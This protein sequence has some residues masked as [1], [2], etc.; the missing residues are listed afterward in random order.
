M[1][2]FKSYDCFVVGQKTRQR[3]LRYR[4]FFRTHEQ[5][6]HGL[7]HRLLNWIIPFS[8]AS[9]FMVITGC[10]KALAVDQ[11]IN[12]ITTTQVFSSDQVATSAMDGI[13]GS[14]MNGSYVSG[15]GYSN[16][17]TTIWCGASADELLFYSVSTLNNQFE[18][19]QLQSSNNLVNLGLWEQPFTIIYSANAMIEGLAAPNG[20]HDSV[21]NEL[22]GEAEVVRAFVNFYLV[23]LFGNIPLVTTTN[24]LKTELLPQTPSTEVYQQIIAD[25]KDAQRRLPGDY[26]VGLGQRII[27]NRYAAAALL[28]TVYLYINDWPDA[29]S[30]AD[31]VIAHSS[32]Y[33]LAPL[34][35]VF[36]ANSSE[37][38]WQLEP[39]PNI[40]LRFNVTPEGYLLIPSTNTSHPFAYLTHQLLNAFDS[41]DQRFTNW[42]DSTSYGGMTYYYP[43]KYKTGSAQYASGGPVTEYYMMLRLG[44]QFLIRAEA[45]ANTGDSADAI[46]DLNMIRSRAG[47]PPYRSV[48]QNSLVAAIQHERQVELFC[49]WG[50]RWLDLKRT[51]EAESVLGAISYKQPWS[52]NALLY[53][54]PYSELTVDPNLVQNTGY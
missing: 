33:S 36:L 46:N 15:V 27:P 21:I 45:E 10:R 11:P 5:I 29:V 51:G 39:D 49:E 14:M 6:V 25:L 32:L 30:E 28:A 1:N 34:S 37:A 2:R 17:F 20:V 8:V 53:P 42:L 22:T 31:S 9:L 50:H 35:G 12:E 52:N 48:V 18:N 19:N 38:I 16:G 43:Y 7:S 54:I 23:N 13:Y 26:S 24:F 3:I 41:G 44:E 40:G 4:R 47:L